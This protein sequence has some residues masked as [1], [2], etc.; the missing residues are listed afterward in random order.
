MA[1]ACRTSLNSIVKSADISHAGLLLSRY[2]QNHD[3][4][5]KGELIEKASSVPSKSSYLYEAA[6]DRWLDI[7]RVGAIMEHVEIDGRAVIGLASAS[8]LETSLTLHHTYGTP[9][10]PGTALKGL[11][12]HYCHSVWGKTD[13]R[14]KRDG[15]YYRTIFGST[16]DSG[17]IIFN[18]AWV[19]PESLGDC[20]VRDVM[21][22]HHPDYYQGKNDDSA[23]SDFDDP[24]PI[25]FLSVKGKY[26]IALKCDVEGVNG[27]SW[28]ELTMVLLR[29]ALENWGVGGKTNAGYGRI[30][31]K[32]VEKQNPEGI[33]PAAVTEKREDP[34]PNAGAKVQA[35]LQ[36]EKTKKGGWKAMY[37]GISGPIQNSTLVP[38]DKKPGDKV[39]LTVIYANKREIGFMWP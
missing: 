29:E 4:N 35:L 39:T 2:L 16:E 12:A 36:A 6:F 32:V 9:L 26:P 33:L 1:Q 7:V 38:P 31:T 28:A 22:V 27:L 21:T 11:A 8:P 17:H 5:T 15:F 14:F 13:D 18:D 34:L 19:M 37:A 10:I 3:N 30:Q 23:P 25:P 24:T 20:L